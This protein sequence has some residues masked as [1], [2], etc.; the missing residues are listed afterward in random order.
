M[1]AGTLAKR[2]APLVRA[3]CEG[4]RRRQRLSYAQMSTRCGLSREYYSVFVAG[5]RT[6][7]FDA[8]LKIYSRLGWDLNELK[9]I[10]R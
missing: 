7:G 5:K 10:A 9:S 3:K 4:Y 1:R 6:F 2:A 8:I